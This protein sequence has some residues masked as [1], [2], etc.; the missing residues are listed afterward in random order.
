MPDV[1]FWYMIL[2]KPESDPLNVAS[3]LFGEN[4]LI[5]ADR[6]FTAKKKQIPIF[7]FY[8]PVMTRI[9]TSAC[10]PRS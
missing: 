2:M 3:A 4:M 1:W 7:W 5:F 8:R 10:N 9:H 6:M